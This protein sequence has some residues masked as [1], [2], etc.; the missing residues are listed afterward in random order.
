[1]VVDG[2]LSRTQHF[3]PATGLTRMVTG[4]VTR[5]A[6]TQRAGRAGRTAPGVA[7]RLWS[8]RTQPLLGAA[9][10]AEILEAD[11]APLTLE[12]AQWGAPDPG[13]L[14]WLDAPRRHASKLPV[15]CCVVLTPWMSRAGPRR[16]VRG[17][18]TF[19]P[20][21]ASRIC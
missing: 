7:Y 19:L 8:E 12:L 10:P 3:D 14:A 21:R 2:G 6:A 9:R 13:A 4:R 18:S 20:I 11:L 1:M 17:C 5:D 16:K 15:P